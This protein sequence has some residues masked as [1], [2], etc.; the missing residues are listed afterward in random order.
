M[1]ASEPRTERNLVAALGSIP[2]FPLPEVVLYPDAVLPLHVFEPRYRVMLRDCLA[3]HGAMVV[4]RLLPGE[5]AFGR[6]RIATVAGA[7]VVAH[8]QTLPDGRSNIVVLGQSRVLLEELDPA[9]D[10][11]Y[12]RARARILADEDVAVPE[13]ERTA[14]LSAAYGFAGAVQ[15]RDPRFAFEMP[16]TLPANRLADVCAFQ[17][18]VDPD[19]RQALLE[20]LDP[21]RRV[22]RVTEELA[23]QHGGLL[24]EAHGLVLN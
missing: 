23:L 7:G 8:H 22:L 24:R 1:N 10:V 12:R 17:L 11:P 6:P 3:T 2:I 18:V 4:T 9:A 14:L 19:A 5:D 21:R 15:K 16:R 13:A 20:E